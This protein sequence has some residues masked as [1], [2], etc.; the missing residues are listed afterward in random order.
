MQFNRATISFLVAI[1]AT[2]GCSVSPAPV[3]EDLLVTGPAF[4][5]SYSELWP[6]DVVD[7]GPAARA[8]TPTRRRA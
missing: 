8:G 5:R 1:L 3:P 6:G 2:V 4:E 7:S